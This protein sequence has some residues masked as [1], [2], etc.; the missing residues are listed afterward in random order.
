MSSPQNIFQGSYVKDLQRVLTASAVSGANAAII[1]P[2]GG[3][4][5]D[6]LG[7]SADLCSEGASTFVE[8]APSSPP[9]MVEGMFN[10]ATLMAAMRGQ[11]IEVLD[12]LTRGTAADSQYRFVVL[13]ELFRAS[14]P[15][16]DACL[17]LLDPKRHKA[18][19]QGRVFW[20]TSN[21]S[22]TDERT[23]ALR[24]RFPLWAHITPTIQD[25]VAFYKAISASFASGLQLQLPE[26]MPTWS[27]IE[28]VRSM[29][30]G[31]KAE[32][33]VIDFLLS[34]EEEIAQPPDPAR[35]DNRNRRQWFI[36][37][38]RY[39]AYLKGSNNFNDLPA[40]AKQIIRYLW[41][42]PTKPDWEAWGRKTRGVSDFVGAILAA[43][44]QHTIGQLNELIQK[45][46]AKGKG[47]EQNMVMQATAIIQAGQREIAQKCGDDDRAKKA[48]AGLQ[49]L[50]IKVASGESIAPNLDL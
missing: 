35:P 31:P 47:D 13:D 49:K 18:A 43:V 26:P 30:V 14:E 38:F 25:E 24:N 23:E 40:E 29:L 44:Q 10:P 15:V 46:K 21:F 6:I 16:F 5:S 32:K 4:K 36:V 20:A 48:K 34:V 7:L 9:A 41:V 19:D 8:L 27:E 45:T 39:T 12:R 37:L 11:Q 33:A 42:Q 2:P 28:E 17:H 3:G 1:G 50:M 22:L